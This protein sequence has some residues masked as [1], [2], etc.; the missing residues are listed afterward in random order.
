MELKGI[1]LCDYITTR[2]SPLQLHYLMSTCFQNALKAK[3]VDIHNLA[4]NRL[5]TL[6]VITMEIIT[7]LQKIM[8]VMTTYFHHIHLH[9]IIKGIS[10]LARTLEKENK[11]VIHCHSLRKE[12]HL[13][14]KRLTTKMLRKN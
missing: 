11:K 10:L 1:Y 14:K 3:N 9:P 12:N 2:S 13:R 7:F 8:M 4:M 6:T 5:M